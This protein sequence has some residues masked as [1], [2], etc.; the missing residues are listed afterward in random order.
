ME[1]V[2][3]VIAAEMD[4]LGI[5]YHYVYNDSVN[6]TYPYATAEYSANDYV[7]EDMSTSADMLLEVWNRGG[8]TPLIEVDKKIKKHFSDFR[9]TSEGFAVCVSY[10]GCYTRRTNDTKLKKLEIHLDIKMWEGE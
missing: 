3:S 7:D 6:I 2:L 1:N 8:Y 5:D 9:F 4:K 10:A